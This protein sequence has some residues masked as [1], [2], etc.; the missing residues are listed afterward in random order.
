M[1]E[2]QA[3][4]LLRE[5]AYELLD[6][7]CDAVALWPIRRSRRGRRMWIICARPSV[8]HIASSPKPP[9]Q[10]RAHRRSRSRRGQGLAPG[11][12]ALQAAIDAGDGLLGWAV[13]VNDLDGVAARLG[14]AITTIGRQ[15]S[16]PYPRR[17]LNRSGAVALVANAHPRLGQSDRRST[18]HLGPTLSG[19]SSPKSRRL[20]AA[21]E[22]QESS[23]DGGQWNAFVW[24]ADRHT[25]P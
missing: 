16:G 13:A 2:A 7:H 9:K 10:L 17:R 25:S 14:T 15:S 1:I 24:A 12:A 21:L 22:P 8:V 4:R 19:V 20:A 6:A 3:T 5:L 18:R 11:G 23:A